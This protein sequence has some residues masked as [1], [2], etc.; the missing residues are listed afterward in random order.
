MQDSSSQQ[1]P[2][3]T[4]D[5]TYEP[6]DEKTEDIPDSDEDFFVVKEGSGL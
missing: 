2:I 6:I 3:A 1:N 5:H 4:V